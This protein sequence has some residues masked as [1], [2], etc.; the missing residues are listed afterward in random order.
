MNNNI[1]KFMLNKRLENEKHN[2][3]NPNFAIFG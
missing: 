2:P 3:N 1:Y